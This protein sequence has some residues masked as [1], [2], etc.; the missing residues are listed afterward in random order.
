MLILGRRVNEKIVITPADGRRIEVMVTA[1]EGRQIKLGITAPPDIVV[2]RGE[3]Q[4]RVD[5]AQKD[6]AA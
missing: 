4:A 3:I 6:D 5:A 2:H 1:I